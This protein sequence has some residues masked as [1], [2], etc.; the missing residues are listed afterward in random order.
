L[1]EEMSA[2][3]LSIASVIA[4]LGASGCAGGGVRVYDPA[5]ASPST[6][7]PVKADY[8]ESRGEPPVC[9]FAW[10]GNHFVGELGALRD[11]AGF[12]S[13]HL[14]TETSLD[15]EGCGLLLSIRQG[16]SA[17]SIAGTSFVDAYSP[18]GG[19]QVLR[20]QAEGG[21]GA[22][23]GFAQIARYLKAEL[24]E[25]RPLRV[26]LDKL[27]ETKPLID[28]DDVSKLAE[29]EPLTWAGLIAVTPDAYG[30]TQLEA[31]KKNAEE[32]AA[33]EAKEEASESG[34]EAG[35]DTA[36]GDAAEPDK[37]WWSKP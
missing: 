24:Q 13:L 27:K 37:P 4:L 35:D 12:R 26:K 6:V 14:L 34:S 18:F 10:H 7:T 3:L 1:V 9:L 25:G 5:Q 11:A 32:H 16:G 8:G 2:R 23:F 21:W 28:E 20:A 30:R 29:G 17:S 22:S 36:E 33:A 19:E 31:S 15:P